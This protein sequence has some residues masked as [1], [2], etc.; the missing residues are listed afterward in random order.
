MRLRL[1]YLYRNIMR[2]GRRSLLTLA[3]VGLPMVIFVLSASVIDAIERFLENSAQ[4]L[5][6]A[7]VQKSSI[8][9]P[10]PEGHRAKIEALDLERGRIRSVCGIHWIGGRVEN[11]S[12]QLSTLAADHDTFLDT[13][14]EYHLTPE[15]R[16]AWLRDRRALIVGEATAGQFNWNVGDRVTILPSVPP[17]EPM[18][19]TVVATSGNAADRVTNWFRRDY[20]EETLKAFGM[21]GGHVSFYYVKCASKDDLDY[22]RGAIDAHF[23]G[24]TDETATQDEKAFMNQFITQQFNLPRNL[25]ILAAVT[26]FVAV[27]AAANTMNMTFRDRIS[28]FATLKSLGFGGGVVFWQVQVESLALCGF[29]GVAGALVPYALFM[30]TP[31]RDV[32]IPVIQTLYIDPLV[33]LQA[34][35]I[36]LGIGLVA[37]LLPSWSA[38]RLHVVTALRSLE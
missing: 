34:V 20:L 16:E 9:N 19:F 35:G 5:R 36:A 14:P 4:Q 1:I 28:E 21:P 37:G 10:L 18:E 23:A 32:N 22:F 8:I 33:C 11:S 26:V 12:V 13:F 7:V 31:L 25:A 38:Y 30:H 3:A 17:Y 6:L 24:S 27:M 15:Q 29:G 2:N